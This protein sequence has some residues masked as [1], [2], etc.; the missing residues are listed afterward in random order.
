MSPDQHP[1]RPPGSPVALEDALRRL[2]GVVGAVVLADEAAVPIEVQVFTEP[3]SPAA[4]I[5]EQVGRVVSEHGAAGSVQRIYV[6]VVD[7]PANPRGAGDD[8]GGDD[9]AGSCQGRV[10]IREVLTSSEGTRSVAR[11]SLTL[12]ERQHTGTAGG[13]TTADNVGIA[14]EAT[15]A[16]LAGLLDQDQPLEVLT[17]QATEI[18]GH[19]AVSVLVS[20]ADGRGLLGACLADDVPL[21]QATV[22]ATL[23]AVNRYLPLRLRAAAETPGGG[24]A[25]G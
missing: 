12:G 16:A 2:P 13:P 8:D 18:A 6:L 23:D 11:V 25:P 21:H 3:G 4:R 9:P 15:V 24:P 20:T 17:T 10:V 1:E 14:A 19:R 22:R 5:R 7:E